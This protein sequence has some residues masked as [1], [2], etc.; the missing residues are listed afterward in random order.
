MDKIDFNGYF[1]DEIREL[2]RRRREECHI[3][4]RKLAALINTSWLTVSNWENGRIRKCHRSFVS[5]VAMFLN[6][7]LDID[8]KKA[9]G[10]YH[11][12]L[13]EIPDLPSWN[14]QNILLKI[15]NTYQFCSHSE[16]IRNQLIERILEQSKKTL[17]QYINSIQNN[18]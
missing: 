3:S 17:L 15:R 18:S 9:S 10:K 1:S 11:K 6:G 12:V 4:Y 5:K 16:D 13:S 14:I 2:F 7:E 8:A